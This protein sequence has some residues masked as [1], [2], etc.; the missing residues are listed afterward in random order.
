MFHVSIAG[1]LFCPPE[2]YDHRYKLQ[3]SQVSHIKLTETVVWVTEMSPDTTIALP[4][5]TT[6]SASSV[7]AEYVSKK[8][9]VPSTIDIM[10]VS[11]SKPNC[12][13]N[14]TV[15]DALETDSGF[16]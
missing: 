1:M 15:D 12:Q 6:T 16:R 7:E 2:F 8:T 9:M 4:A 10:H 11:E 13:D 3:Q 14:G 5:E